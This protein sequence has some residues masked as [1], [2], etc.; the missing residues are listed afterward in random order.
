MLTRGIFWK[1]LAIHRKYLE[2]EKGIWLAI[3]LKLSLNPFILKT[4][5]ELQLKCQTFDL[6]SYNEMLINTDMLTFRFWLKCI[7]SLF[8]WP[9]ILKIKQIVHLLNVFGIAILS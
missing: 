6:L 2:Y 7:S 4:L 1:Y 3:L 5:K 8:N 9:I